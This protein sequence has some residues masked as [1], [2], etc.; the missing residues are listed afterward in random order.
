MVNKGK[1]MPLTA[2]NGEI[3]KKMNIKFSN[4]C[5]SVGVKT[6]YLCDRIIKRTT[7]PHETIP[8]I[9]YYSTSA[10]IYVYR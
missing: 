7:K 3:L 6:G 1:K 8:L 9:L 5:D 10:L 2:E 4:G